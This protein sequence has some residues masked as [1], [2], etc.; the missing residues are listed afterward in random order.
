MTMGD[1]VAVLK[2]GVL[3]QLDPPSRLYRR[4]A[5]VFVGGFIGSPAMNLVEA[6]VARDDGRLF[7]EFGQN[8]VAI[9]EKTAQE[10]PALHGYVGRKLILGIRPEDMED[11]QLRSDAPAERRILTSVDLREDMGSEVLVHF[12]VDA[13]PVLTED[14]K[15]LAADIGADVTDLI[16]DV[17]ATTFIAKF[18]ANT[19]AQEGTRIEVF[20]DTRGLHFF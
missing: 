2:H 8:R 15:E 17:T 10:R 12:T 6:G 20:V 1:Q 3:Q 16:P 13:P 11:A 7:V 5:N 14:T 4:P 9:D 18:D 19:Q